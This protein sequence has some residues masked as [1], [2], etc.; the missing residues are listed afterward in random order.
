MREVES[1]RQRQVG[2]DQVPEHSD[3]YESARRH[4]AW[5]RGTRYADQQKSVA[6][7]RGDLGT[8]PGDAPPR[9]AGDDRGTPL[10][11]HQG[12]DGA[13]VETPEGLPMV[14]WRPETPEDEQKR[15]GLDPAVRQKI[16]EVVRALV[17]AR[18]DALLIAISPAIGQLGLDRVPS[19]DP[20]QD[21][22]LRSGEMSLGLEGL[23][24]KDPSTWEKLLVVLGGAAVVSL[25]DSLAAPKE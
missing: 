18:R 22:V 2:G 24:L 12:K 8:L 17:D 15:A 6:P 3:V 16:E 25:T 19:G 7:R 5:M 20:R 1:S 4:V 9:M 23:A 14:D 11:G 21:G 10:F 13:P